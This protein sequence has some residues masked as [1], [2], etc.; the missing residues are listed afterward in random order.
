MT[1]TQET[2]AAAF[3]ALV[4]GPYL[5]IG[6]TFMQDQRALYVQ[7]DKNSQ[8]TANCM[9]T[10]RPVGSL[11]FTIM[12]VPDPTLEGQQ[13]RIVYDH[14]TNAQYY[15][16]RA[17]W[18]PGLKIHTSLV[19]QFVVDEIDNCK[20]HNL[21]VFDILRYEG[22]DMSGVAPQIRYETLRKIS[23]NFNQQFMTLQWV[24]ENWAIERFIRDN[25]E[26]HR[27]PHEIQYSITLSTD[28]LRPLTCFK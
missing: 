13:V 10:W 2:R 11:Y 14:E 25:Q 4:A 6:K 16:Q 18:T 9:S 7:S 15:L 23:E 20:R 26:F 3:E 1:T 28:P 24:G 19:A 21:M 5:A 17:A 27:L 22:Q 8:I 12:C